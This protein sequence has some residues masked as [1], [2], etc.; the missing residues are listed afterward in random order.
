MELNGDKSFASLK[1]DRRRPR[2]RRA[3]CS[4]SGRL[5]LVD[6]SISK[7]SAGMTA[8][9]EKAPRYR[10]K[11][12]DSQRAFVGRQHPPT[13]SAG[14]SSPAENLPPATWHSVKLNSRRQAAKDMGR[15]LRIMRRAE[16]RRARTSVDLSGER[17]SISASAFLERHQVR[18]SHIGAGFHRRCDKEQ[19]T[20]SQAATLSCKLARRRVSARVAV[21]STHTQTRSESDMDND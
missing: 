18:R 10:N 21:T 12:S 7:K 1:R 17:I 3:D 2:T 8:H 20:S 19:M 15:R 4:K 11:H 9:R 6:P 13:W 14:L 16:R 5:I